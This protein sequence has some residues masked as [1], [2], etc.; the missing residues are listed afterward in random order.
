MHHPSDSNAP[1][2]ASLVVLTL[3]DLRHVYTDHVVIPSI[4]E[5]YI[6]GF[7]AFREVPHYRVLV[8]RVKPTPHCPDVILVD[9][10][11]TLHPRRCGSA[12]HLGVQA[13]IATVGV[14]KNLLMVDGGCTRDD[15]QLELQRLWSLPDNHI[16][17][18]WLNLPAGVQLPPTCRAAPLYA[19]GPAST[20][21]ELVGAAV[22]VAHGQRPVYVSVGHL[23]SLATAVRLVVQC[24]R[25][26][27][28]EPVRL[29]DMVSSETLRA[30]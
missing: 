7:L 21:R 2:V 16:D 15:V 1:A 8:D 18:S 23:V 20:T 17:L 22:S 26:R 29:A 10:S 14:A 5:P 30:R 6:P 28:P 27:V 25:Y 4:P 13:H 9:G 11:G 12:C 19:S 24:C 3:P